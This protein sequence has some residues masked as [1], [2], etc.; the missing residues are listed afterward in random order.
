MIVLHHEDIMAVRHQRGKSIMLF[1]T[2][3]CPVECK[4]CSV[5]ATK[6]GPTIQDY[7]LF[8]SLLDHALELPSLEVVGVSGGEPFVE[9]KGLQMVAAK[10]KAAQKK[11]VIYTSGVWA[12]NKKP[13]PWIQDVLS[14][15]VTVYLSTDQFHAQ[16]VTSTM[17]VNAA[18]AIAATD[19]WI[20][21]QT[22]EPEFAQDLLSKAFGTQA[23]QFSEIQRITPLAN[24]RGAALFQWPY[25][26]PGH[27]F[28]A[29]ELALSPT[30][31]YDGTVTGCCNE[32]VI[33][34]MGPGHLRKRISDGKELPVAVEEFFEDSLMKVIRGVGLGALTF[35]P[36]FKDLA[37]ER[38]STNC[39]LCWKA[40]SRI[41]D[42]PLDDPLIHVIADMEPL[43]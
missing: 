42:K 30:I 3:R 31:R 25:R 26:V 11:L 17:F 6:N 39:D 37:N 14:Q 7:E 2:D 10:V 29:C 15:C 24:G 8:E 23:D 16:V 13:P 21:V 34:G 12:V 27:V 41:S 9:K 40:L 32:E 19:A 28:G 5:S 1:L 36:Q 4:H 33:M 22:L 43:R 38:F 20:V 35:H 18:R